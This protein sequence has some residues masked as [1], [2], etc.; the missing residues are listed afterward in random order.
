[1]QGIP[2]RLIVVDDKYSGLV[3]RHNYTIWLNLT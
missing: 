1:L 2:H 3:V